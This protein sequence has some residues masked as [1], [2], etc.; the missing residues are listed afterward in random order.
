MDGTHDFLNVAAKPTV[1]E[2]RWGSKRVGTN[3]PQ[4]RVGADL[5]RAD[6]PPVG[7]PVVIA[8]PPG[9]LRDYGGWD[10][11]ELRGREPQPKPTAG[12]PSGKMEE[13][14][15]RRLNSYRLVPGPSDADLVQP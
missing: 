11:R 1:E 2:Q 8:V 5:V 4:H 7:R 10:R 13:W 6:A 9:T 15:A 3:V 12:T 14:S